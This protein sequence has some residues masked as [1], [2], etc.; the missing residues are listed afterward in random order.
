MLVVDEMV[1]SLARESEKPEAGGSHA[2]PA[3]PGC[4]TGTAG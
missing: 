4:K 1:V 2:C 3:S